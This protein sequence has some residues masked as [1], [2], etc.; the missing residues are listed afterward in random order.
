[1]GGGGGGGMTEVTRS[2]WLMTT[3]AHFTVCNL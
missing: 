2:L 3:R 1:M